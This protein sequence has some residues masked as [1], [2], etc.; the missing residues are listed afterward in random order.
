MPQSSFK[1]EWDAHEY[2][3]KERSPDWFWAVG[4]IAVSIAI[5]AIIFGNIILGI[6]ILIG[7]FALSLFASRP[8]DTLHIII[9][10]KGITKGKIR[11][12]YSTLESFWIDIEHPHKKI[13]LRSGKIFM[14]L[15]IIPLGDEADT[16]QLHEKLL[17]SMPEEFHSLPFVERLLEYLGF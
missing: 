6:L 5:A 10:E 14:P 13:I 12:P 16:E 3:H 1:I 4:I 17:H 9:D 11:Y 15:I 8:P 7:A 2:E